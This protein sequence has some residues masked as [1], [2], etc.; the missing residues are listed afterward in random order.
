[1]EA[2]DI[3]QIRQSLGVSQDEFAKLL[4]VSYTTVSRWENGV[5]SPDEETEDQLRVLKKLVDNPDIDK[6][7]IKNLMVGAGLGV[8]VALGVLS[9]LA[10]LPVLGG[11]LGIFMGIRSIVNAKEISKLLRKEKGGG[12]ND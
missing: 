11:A 2:K 8:P 6:R 9:G 10:G 12:E 1:M 5:K 7:K 3:R 4:R